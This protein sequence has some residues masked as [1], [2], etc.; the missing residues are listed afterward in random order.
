MEKQLTGIQHKISRLQIY[1]NN[2]NIKHQCTFKTVTMYLNRIQPEL[3]WL[4]KMGYE[5]EWNK[6]NRNVLFIKTQLPANM[7]DLIQ[8]SVPKNIRKK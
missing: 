4:Q 1:I 2:Y 3:Q 7:K 6:V 8:D 5:M